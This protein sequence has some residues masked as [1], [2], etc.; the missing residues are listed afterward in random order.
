MI[1]MNTET[2]I[3]MVSENM[4]VASVR[5]LSMVSTSFPKRLMIRPNGV[6]S[7]KDIGARRT[8]SYARCSMVLLALVP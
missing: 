6:V 7:K 1:R 5:T 4:R 3:A 8:R 2:I